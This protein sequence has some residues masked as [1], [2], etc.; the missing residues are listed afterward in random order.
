MIKR[1]AVILKQEQT[2]HSWSNTKIEIS[3]LMWLNVLWTSFQ[4]LEVNIY[5]YI[6]CELIGSSVD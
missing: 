3:R 5:I 4:S 6:E 2:N 1:T